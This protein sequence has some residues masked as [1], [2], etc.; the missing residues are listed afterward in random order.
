M[1]LSSKWD[2]GE[3]PSILL[4]HN[5]L[6]SQAPFSHFKPQKRHFIKIV[7]VKGPDSLQQFYEKIE[8]VA[9]LQSVLLNRHLSSVAESRE[10]PNLTFEAATTECQMLRL[11]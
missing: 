4:K 7:D 3:Y 6:Y 2:H 8:T 10:N 11:A 9:R 5:H 1:R